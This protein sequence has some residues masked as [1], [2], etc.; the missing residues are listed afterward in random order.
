MVCNEEVYSW[1]RNLRGSKRIEAMCCF[2]NMCYPLELRF[3]GTCLED[4]GRKDFY[5]LKDDE[6]KANDL[7]E[8][9][10]IRNI[11]D[12]NTRCKLIVT[13][14]LL[15]STNTICARELFK[16]LSE[17]IKIE[18]LASMGVLSDF[19]LLEHYLLVLT[20]AQH[21]PAFT[22][23]QQTFLINLSQALETYVTDLCSKGKYEESYLPSSY[24]PGRVPSHGIPE[25]V[26]S[27]VPYSYRHTTPRCS[28]SQHNQAQ[29]TSLKVK[30]PHK[31]TC[32]RIRVAWGNNKVTDAF[33]T[34]HDLLVFHQKLVQLFPT[35]AKNNN[36][37]K[38]IPPLPHVIGSWNKQSNI[39]DCVANAASEYIQQLNSRLPSYVVETDF[40]RSFFMPSY[41][42]RAALNRNSRIVDSGSMDVPQRNS[43]LRSLTIYNSRM[44]DNSPRHHPENRQKILPISQR[45]QYENG[46]SMCSR[47]SPLNSPIES[48]LSS[49]YAS[50]LNS[51][52]NS[53]APSPWNIPPPNVGYSASSSCNACPESPGMEK[54]QPKE[55]ADQWDSFQNYKFEE[56]QAMPVQE[57]EALGIIKDTG[58]KLAKDPDCKSPPNGIIGCYIPK[59]AL[60]VKSGPLLHN[61]NDSSPVCSEY[62]SPPQSPSPGET[63][64]QSSSLSSGNEENTE[65][66]SLS[67]TLSEMCKVDETAATVSDSPFKRTDDDSVCMKGNP[68]RSS[69][70]V[71]PFAVPYS[72]IVTPIPPP[73]S[74]KPAYLP[75]TCRTNS[76]PQHLSPGAVVFDN[77][78]SR[79][80]LCL[81]SALTT[82]LPGPQRTHAAT[83]DRVLSPSSLPISTVSPFPVVTSGCTT[84]PSA[85]CSIT[86]HRSSNVTAVTHSGASSNRYTP[87]NSN[88]ARDSDIVSKPVQQTAD[89]PYAT[90]YILNTSTQLT[91][92]SC[93]CFT[94]NSARPSP[95]PSPSVMSPGA[96]PQPSAVPVSMSYLGMPTWNLFHS[97]PFLQAQ[98]P[99]NGFVPQAG[100]TN[101]GQGFSYTL[102]NGM[103]AI[104]PE[105]IYPGQ[106]F[107]IQSPSTQSPVAATPVTQ[108]YGAFPQTAALPV[109]LG[110]CYN[111]GKVGHR[112]PECKEQTMDDMNKS[113]KFQLNYNPV[114]KIS[115]CH[116]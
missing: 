32:L 25:K 14:S 94:T 37:E 43:R 99:A 38:C 42:N 6:I 103:T 114:P 16:V 115:D 84:V 53:R 15:N 109:K 36:Q 95:A 19:K 63:C 79:V 45:K 51:E 87:K 4:L 68:N 83:P 73:Q 80:P 113:G 3:Y 31:K 17:E 27:N 60:Y 62:S 30:P 106:T 76:G 7:T 86:T 92:V 46:S 74:M 93:S 5:V 26:F 100:M 101:S 97:I 82:F 64:N 67:K 81:P 18:I 85:S 22:F 35:E 78:F 1:F 90:G 9:L 69:V 2:L 59:S 116:E 72:S 47:P 107:T 71:I 52:T 44:S 29:I 54:I 102:P 108:C 61:S 41:P 88:V 89:G 91:A 13:L 104:S 21:H 75:I 56:L 58:V 40:F 65:K 112:G 49:P 110:T 12:M 11:H 24:V 23:E 10:K 57:L 50:P 8:V 77:Q 28:E 39:T 70:S 96:T 98:T 55:I 105:L 20:L 111:C 66:R 34:P 48:P 33:K